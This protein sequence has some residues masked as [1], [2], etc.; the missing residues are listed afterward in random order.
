MEQPRELLAA[1]HA[2][3]HAT[4]TAFPNNITTV[5]PSFSTCNSVFPPVGQ[6]PTT[7]GPIPYGFNS[8]QE[9]VDTSRALQPSGT[10]SYGTSVVYL[11]REDA[12]TF[13]NSPLWPGPLQPIKSSNMGAITSRPSGVYPPSGSAALALFDDRDRPNQ[14]PS[15]SEIEP[16]LY[17]GNKACVEDEK[18]L[19]KMGITAVITVMSQ[20]VSNKQNHPLV[21]TIPLQDRF[22]VQAVDDDLQ[23]I[24]QYF[25]GACDFIDKRLVSWPS[26]PPPPTPFHSHSGR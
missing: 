12:G 26:S 18:F 21:R 6:T 5:Q 24:I 19:R 13:N 7:Q 15:I 17:L 10:R 8:T 4:W 25:P 22:F 3:V 9:P 2:T 16:G 23:D 20:P 1:I 11:R 14:K